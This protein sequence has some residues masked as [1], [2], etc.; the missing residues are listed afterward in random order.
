M[1]FA[2]K[3]LFS[4]FNCINIPQFSVIENNSYNFVINSL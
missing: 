1:N 3:F 4:V 2:D